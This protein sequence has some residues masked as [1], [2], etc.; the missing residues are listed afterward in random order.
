MASGNPGSPG[1]MSPAEAF[2]HLRILVWNLTSYSNSRI[3]QIA[4][5]FV[6]MSKESPTIA[7]GCHKAYREFLERSLAMGESRR[8]LALLYVCN[9]ILTLDPL[10]EDWQAVLADAMLKSV[11]LICE[12][13][14]RQQVRDVRH[15]AMLRHAQHMLISSCVPVAPSSAFF[16]PA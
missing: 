12:L 10:D 1:R 15:L 9:E 5:A 13:A 2:E 6:D 11:P 16:S 8:C 7:S 14:T 3:V 4:K